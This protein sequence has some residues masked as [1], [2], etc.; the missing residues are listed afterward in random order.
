MKKKEEKT[1]PC[2]KEAY[3]IQ[4]KQKYK[5]QIKTILIQRK[6]LFFFWSNS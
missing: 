4:K 3:E 5:K 1:V 6:A 2:V